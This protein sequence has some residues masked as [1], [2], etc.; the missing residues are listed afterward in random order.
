MRFIP[1]LDTYSYHFHADAWE[2][3]APEPWG[4]ERL[5]EKAAELDLKALQSADMRHFEPYSKNEEW[6]EEAVPLLAQSLRRKGLDCELGTGGFDLKHLRQVLRLAE[7]LNVRVLR[8]FLGGG[9]WRSD[10]ETRERLGQAAESFSRLHPLL[11]Q[12]N[13]FLAIENHQDLTSETLQRFLL[14]LNLP[15][16]GVCLDTGNP[17]GVIEDPLSAARRLAP[18]TFSVH[19]KDYHLLTTGEGYVIVGAVPGDGVVPLPEILSLLFDQSPRDTL[20]INLECAVEYIPIRPQRPGWRQEYAPLA[21]TLLESVKD[22]DSPEGA[23]LAATLAKAR[24][25]NDAETVLEMENRM[26]RDG[27]ERLRQLMGDLQ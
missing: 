13:A 26:V 21:R 22:A 7:L 11:E 12:Q 3:L 1:G 25:E 14:D 4:I 5:I 16:I 27:A 8:T 15:R 24:D 2:Q 10:S 6:D 20:Q 17:L 23:A 9:V 18:F 19:L